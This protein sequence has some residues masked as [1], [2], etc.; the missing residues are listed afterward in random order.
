MIF[1]TIGTHE[2]F[3]RLVRAVDEWCDPT[4][5]KCEV[6]GQ[7]TDRGRYVPKNFDWI[8]SL[9][10]DAYREH[11][12]AAEFII[13][14]AGMGSIITAM[15]YGRPIVVLPR[16]GHLKETRNDH[17]YATAIRLRGHSGLMVALSETELPRILDFAVARGGWEST[18][19]IGSFADPRLTDMLRSL[20]D[21]SAN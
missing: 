14:H 17:Q 13:S 7:I 15:T 18:G 20:I 10:P 19:T 12:R 2:P 5:R 6:F 8:P 21:R 3:D 4:R 16:R 1:L 11:C 9:P